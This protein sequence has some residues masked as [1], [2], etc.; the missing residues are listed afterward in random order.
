M[1]CGWVYG[2][3]AGWYLLELWWV[4]SHGGCYVE[5]WLRE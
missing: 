5:V 3:F 2:W 4:W 1:G